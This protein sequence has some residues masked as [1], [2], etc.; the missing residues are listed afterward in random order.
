MFEN[1]FLASVLRRVAS[2][3]CV[4]FTPN[5]GTSKERTMLHAIE[6]GKIQAGEAGLRGLRKDFWNRGSNCEQR[7]IL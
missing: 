7:L 3:L 6:I 5:S 1:S 4:I 2:P